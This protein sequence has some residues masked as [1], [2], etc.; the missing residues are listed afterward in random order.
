[1]PHTTQTIVFRAE[2]RSDADTLN[3]MQ[4]W[5]IDHPGAKQCRPRCAA[6]A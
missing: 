6:V 4:I 1:M 2:R 3:G 5:D